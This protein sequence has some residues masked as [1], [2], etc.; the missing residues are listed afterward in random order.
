MGNSTKLSRDTRIKREVN[1]LRRNLKTVP[2]DR[3]QLAI[4]LVERAAFLRVELE[5]LEAD[6]NANG[7]IEWYQPSEDAAPITRIRAAA[8]Q[9]DKL[10]KS[11]ATVCRQIADLV[12]QG[13]KPGE[14]EKP[15]SDAFQNL[16]EN[17]TDGRMRRVK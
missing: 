7:T 11:Y 10:V 12:P 15:A 4:G 9:Y 3:Q 13:N 1:R 17:R 2:E 8:Q 14:K 16:V 5:D 6:I